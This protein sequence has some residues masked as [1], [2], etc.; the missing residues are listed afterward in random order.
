LTASQ[1]NTEKDD[2]PTYDLLDPEPLAEKHDA[3]SDPH[4]CNQVLVD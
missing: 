4:G 2:R 3:R 1:V